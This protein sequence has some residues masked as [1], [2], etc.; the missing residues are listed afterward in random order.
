MKFKHL[1]LAMAIC[2]GA[3]FAG[4]APGAS[5]KIEFPAPSPACTIKQHIGLTDIEVVYSRPGVKDRTIFG[6]LVPYGEVWRTGANAATKITFSTPVKLNG[7]DIAAGTYGL[8]TIPGDDEWTIIINKG[9]DQWGAYQ[10][11]EKKDLVRFKTKPVEL[12]FSIETFT[13]EFNHV[14]DESALM[15]LMWDKTIVPIRL[16]VEL[17]SKLVPQIEATMSAEGGDKPYYQAAMFY[18]DHDQD[19]Q[20]ASKWIDAAIAKNDAHYMEY[21]KAKILAKLGNKTEA[22][23][24]A[25]HS[26][27]LA[28]KAKDSGYIKLNDDLITSLQ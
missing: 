11:D 18:Y 16:E 19:L 25:K 7:V 14:R 4:N 23:A 10:Y 20:K 27:E 6:G 1:S 26:K 8:F 12:G 9:S 5:T 15:N 21:L 17:T 2:A 3:F 22:I 24:A 28:I 13:I